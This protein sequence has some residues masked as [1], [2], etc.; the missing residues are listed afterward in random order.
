LLAIDT[1]SERFD[2]LGGAT[3]IEGDGTPIPAACESGMIPNVRPLLSEY[4]DQH[5]LNSTAP[6]TK[7]EYW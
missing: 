6:V 2:L 4:Q 5:T 3:G 7:I 1:E